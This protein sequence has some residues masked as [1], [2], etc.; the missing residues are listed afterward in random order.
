[1]TEHF[2]RVQNR[3]EQ[4]EKVL[5]IVVKRGFTHW[6]ITF[7]GGKDSTSTAIVALERAI[8]LGAALERIDLVYADTTIE[9]PSISKFAKDFLKFIKKD[10]R[11]KDLNLYCHVF[12]PP[13]EKRYWVNLLGKGYPPPHQKFRWCTRRLKIEPVKDKLRKFINANSTVIMTGVRFGESKER[14]KRLNISCSRGGECGQGLWFNHSKKLEAAYLAP[15]VDWTDCDVWDFI[16]LIAP[17]YGYPT[18]ELQNIYNGHNTRFGCWTCTVVKQD[19]AMERTIAQEK[20]KHLYPMA[21]FR[22]YLWE[23]TRSRETRITRADGNPGKLKIKVR[24]KLLKRL[25]DIQDKVNMKL[26]DDREVSSIEKIWENEL[27]SK[28]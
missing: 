10:D 18:H 28:D 6:L 3:I 8:E 16:T 1:M 21:E 11:F 9:I 20:W 7:S 23:K 2:L 26:I 27:Q 12:K 13:M 17:A 25:L 22:N 14:D 24:K 4:T 15:I 5:D 19:K